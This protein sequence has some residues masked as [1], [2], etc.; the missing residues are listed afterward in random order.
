MTKNMK[1]ITTQ[2]VQIYM[3]NK[4]EQDYISLTDIARYKDADRTDYLIQNW[5][6]TRDSIEFLGIWAVVSH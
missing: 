6:R 2:G 3:F 5:M 4:N 1:K